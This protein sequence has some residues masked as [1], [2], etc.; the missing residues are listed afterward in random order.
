MLR[1]F[2]VLTLLVH[3]SGTLGRASSREMDPQCN[4][5]NESR[6]SIGSKDFLEIGMI[7][8]SRLWTS[9][10]WIIE[11]YHS[12][13]LFVCRLVKV[14]PK[15]SNNVLRLNTLLSVMFLAKRLD[16]TSTRLSHISHKYLNNEMWD[17]INLMC[18]FFSQG[19]RAMLVDKDK[20]PQ[21]NTR[22]EFKLV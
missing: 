21:V 6:Y 12:F 10:L 3:I 15:L 18:L 13:L 4:N 8:I 11:N 20:K 22:Y 17:V 19:S 16:M 14:G 2:K 7:K 9:S 1:C 5:I